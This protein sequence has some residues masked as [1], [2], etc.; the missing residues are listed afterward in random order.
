MAK[1]YDFDEIKKQLSK[2]DIVVSQ[3]SA[4]MHPE[5]AE[6]CLEKYCHFASTSYISPNLKKLDQEAKDKNLIFINEIGLDPGIDH[7]F[8]HLL[9]SELKKQ[10]IKDCSVSYY[11]YCG[12]I[13]AVSNDFK[14]KFS[15]SP[16]GVLKALKSPS[17][18]IKNGIEWN[19]ER[20]WDAI[21]SY[22]APLPEP[23]KFDLYDLS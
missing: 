19:V 6:V 13:P 22:V 18:S 4:N 2:G 10:N 11:S 1:K 17:K 21:T 15:W 12:G 23:E 20:P 16:A 5:I 14:Y 3:L 8:S 9:V 7:F